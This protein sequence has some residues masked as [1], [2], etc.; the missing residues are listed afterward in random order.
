MAKELEIELRIFR[1]YED[2]VLKV[3][4]F[5]NNSVLRE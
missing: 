2:C 4:S 3:N 1:V 5:L